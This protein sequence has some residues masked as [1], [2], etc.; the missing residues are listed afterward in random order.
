MDNSKF[1]ADDDIP[2]GTTILQPDTNPLIEEMGGK[3]GEPL[4]PSVNRGTNDDDDEEEN[5]LVQLAVDAATE[6]ILND[7]EIPQDSQQASGT[8]N[9]GTM[10]S[11]VNV[12]DL[13]QQLSNQTTGSV[14]TG[15][16]GGGANNTT[17]S[18]RP[19]A[20]SSSMQQ[21]QMF[22]AQ[23]TTSTIPSPALEQNLAAQAMASPQMFAALMPFFVQW[24]QL[25]AQR[26][27]PQQQQPQKQYW[28]MM[29]QLLQQ[30]LASSNQATASQVNADAVCAAFLQ[31]YMYSQVRQPQS[32]GMLPP[33][34]VPTSA[35][36]AA[37]ILAWY[38]AGVQPVLAG[39][40]TAIPAE[41]QPVTSST[42]FGDA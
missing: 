5:D 38:T 18:P 1:T 39:F 21:P 32:G 28:P 12:Q 29:A 4:S 37:P 40:N 23:A 15:A 2:E 31:T 11:T 26:E 22:H 17:P 10:Y 41:V 27:T 34:F 30:L 13:P 16:N 9:N 8:E 6:Q 7:E 25:L 3:S 20:P 36:P 35:P 19:P 33:T 24:M 14:G 42:S